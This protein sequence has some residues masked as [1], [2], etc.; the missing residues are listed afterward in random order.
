M[1]KRFTKQYKYERKDVFLFKVFQVWNAA[2]LL[3][4]FKPFL[5]MSIYSTVENEDL[6][7]TWYV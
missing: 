5:Q 1:N 6:L 4:A 7:Y 3:L 2:I